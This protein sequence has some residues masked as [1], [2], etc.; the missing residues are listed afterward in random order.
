MGHRGLACGNIFDTRHACAVQVVEVKISD[1][2][3]NSHICMPACRSKSGLYRSP[4]YFLHVTYYC[5][6]VITFIVHNVVS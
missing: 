4:R 6:A 5:T 2:P 3:G 1:Y